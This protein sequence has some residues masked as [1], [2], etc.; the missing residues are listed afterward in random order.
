MTN[1]ERRRR[2][3]HRP[4]PGKYSSREEYRT[5]NHSPEPE[6]PQ[7]VP[8]ET[9][10]R[11]LSSMTA[12]RRAAFVEHIRQATNHQTAPDI[13]LEEPRAAE[14]GMLALIDSI[15]RVA[16]SLATAS[17]A[18]V[19]PLRA[20]EPEL[21]ALTNSLNQVA[22]IIENAANAAVEDPR[23]FEHELPTT[24]HVVP[25]TT[26]VG[27]SWMDTAGAYLGLQRPS[28]P[29]RPTQPSTP[30]TRWPSPETTEPADLT[31]SKLSS[32]AAQPV[33]APP[34]KTPP[35]PGFTLAPAVITFFGRKG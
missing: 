11:A 21:L 4:Q 15:N 23:A 32:S 16:A 7:G 24:G 14:P 2:T 5:N 33:V 25:N 30:H 22:T 29:L 17:N 28:Y 8:Q 26:W 12:E 18:F 31:E 1:Y 3:R 19:V 13:S 35:Y 34:L 27:A 10:S 6:A 20:F 9:W